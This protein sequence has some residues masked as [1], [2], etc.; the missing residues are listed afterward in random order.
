[1]LQLN[2]HHELPTEKM[3]NAEK[4]TCYFARSAQSGLGSNRNNWCIIYSCAAIW[5]IFFKS[6]RKKHHSS[7]LSADEVPKLQP[8]VMSKDDTFIEMRPVDRVGCG[9]H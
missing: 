7:I 1:M 5:K 8:N 9:R 6:S 4:I 3:E 2:I